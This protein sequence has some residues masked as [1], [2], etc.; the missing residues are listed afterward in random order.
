MS[1]NFKGK[2]ILISEENEKFLIKIEITIYLKIINSFLKKVKIGQ[3]NSAKFLLLN[4][5]S[6]V[7]L[8]IIEFCIYHKGKG[9]TKSKEIKNYFNSNFFKNSWLVQF[10]K[11]NFRKLYQIILTC[12]FLGVEKL[13][14]SSIYF[15]SKTIAKKASNK[16]KT[17]ARKKIG[18]CKF[19]EV[20]ATQGFEPWTAG[21]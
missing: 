3:V 5:Q 13:L 16:I 12:S 20:L 7:L 8:K 2:I 17:F 10:F 4:I 1:P 21:L 6:E 15:I 19:P 18:V 14:F 9:D 11:I